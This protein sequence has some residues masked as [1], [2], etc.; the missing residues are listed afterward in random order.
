MKRLFWLILAALMTSGMAFAQVNPAD[1]TFT[2]VL[3]AP[4]TPG[5]PV[6]CD[7]VASGLVGASGSYTGAEVAINNAISTCGASSTPTFIASTSGTTLTVTSYTASG[8]VKFGQPV[9]TLGPIYLGMPLNGAGISSQYWVTAFQTG[10]GGVGKYTLNASPGTIGSEVMTGPQGACKLLLKN[11]T[12]NIC[13]P[14]VIDRSFIDI[15]GQS[16]PMWGS[17]VTSMAGGVGTTVGTVN[18]GVTK[19]Q[20]NFNCAGG[21]AY[22][23]IV[24]SD[25]NVPDDGENRHRA[26]GLHYLY[27]VGG[28]LQAN[29]TTIGGASY[30]I[31][32][33]SGNDDSDHWDHLMVQHWFQAIY[34]KLDN[35]YIDHVNVQDDYNGI[36]LTGEVNHVTQ[37]L[38]YDVN[39]VGIQVGNGGGWGD[40]ITDSEFGDCGGACAVI[41]TSSTISGSVFSSGATSAIQLS[42]RST[43]SGNVIDETNGQ[44]SAKTRAAAPIVS[45]GSG[46]QTCSI[47]GN[48]IAPNGTELEYAI[49]VSASSNCTVIGNTIATG[50]NNGSSTSINVGT[51]N[52]VTDNNGDSH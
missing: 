20:Q 28:N 22:N 11:G 5:Q 19:I 25:L 1:T 29:Y 44:F 31:Y 17:Y 36:D 23:A 47:T 32:D 10:T 42:V 34:A 2:Q 45:V 52:T 40:Q 49:D 43:A 33:F 24:L 8:A 39:N 14:I 13:A 26:Q 41:A 4:D 37:M 3:C 30:G 27:I 48:T 38:A 7:A 16:T 50:F 35:A 12:Y 9:N 6:G 15:Y 18:A 51:G 21:N 46:A